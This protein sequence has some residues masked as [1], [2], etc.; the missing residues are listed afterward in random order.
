M[1]VL[2]N[3]KLKINKPRFNVNVVLKAVNMPDEMREDIII[4]KDKQFFTM[5]DIAEYLGISYHVIS[6]IHEGKTKGKK[7]TSDVLCPTITIEKI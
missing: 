4:V 7:W 2:E 6:A 3:G 1:V 5:R